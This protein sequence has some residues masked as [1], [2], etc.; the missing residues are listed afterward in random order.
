MKTRPSTPNKRK[1]DNMPKKHK[2]WEGS[3]PDLKMT[4]DDRLER[5]NKNLT[6]IYWGMIHDE[7]GYVKEDLIRV[8]D[9]LQA[10]ADEQAV[11]TNGMR[12]RIPLF[13]FSKN[14]VC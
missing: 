12:V 6:L 7:V 1:E 2:T 3:M 10:I 8:R 13:D 9:I 11:R 4:E 5:F 14:P